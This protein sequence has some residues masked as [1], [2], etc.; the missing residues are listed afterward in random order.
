MLARVIEILAD[1]F[2]VCTA[3]T[4]ENIFVKSR[5]KVKKDKSIKVGD[6]VRL[7]KVD[8]EFIIESIETRK[9]DYI[10]PPVANIDYMFIVIAAGRPKPDFL[11]LDKQIMTAEYNNCIPVIVVNKS[12]LEQAEEIIKYVKETYSKI[13]YNVIVTNTIGNKLLNEELFK[14]LS[15][16]MLCAFSG[17]SGVGKSS[18][19]SKLREENIKPDINSISE[20]TGKGRHTTKAVTVYNVLNDENKV[21][22]FLDTPGF[23]SYEIYN[24]ESK[25]LKHYY[26]E[27][28]DFKCEYDDCNH[29]NE[30]IKH[31]AIKQ[32][33]KSDKID[34]LRYE[35]Y[36]KIYEEIKQKEKRLYK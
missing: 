23:S 30:D 36:I 28:K 31:C 10:R 13:G 32:A 14:Q 8:N 24:I 25:E 9:N 35:N 17:N 1:R 33:V 6:L 4:Y 15:S 22:Y 12:D 21:I 26:N 34:K 16:G 3:D 27:F 2:K 7:S 18:I 11:L 20:K 5:G 19:I 29:I